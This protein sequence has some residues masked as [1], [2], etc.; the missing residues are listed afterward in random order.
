MVGLR[1]VGYRGFHVQTSPAYLIASIMPID[2]MDSAWRAIVCIVTSVDDFDG[3]SAF[4]GIAQTCATG[5]G[6]S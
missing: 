4:G 1:G 5:L 2:A 3:A 6:L